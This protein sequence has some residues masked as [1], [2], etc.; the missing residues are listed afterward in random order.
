MWKK[1]YVIY[2]KIEKGRIEKKA[3]KTAEGRENEEKEKEVKKKM[4]E[5]LFLN[6]FSFTV[7]YVILQK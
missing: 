7:C 1:Y 5:N 2:E 4:M 6:V 3:I